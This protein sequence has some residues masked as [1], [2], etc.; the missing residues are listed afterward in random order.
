MRGSALLSIPLA[1]AAVRADATPVALT[2]EG[3]VLIQ[4]EGAIDLLEDDG[5]WASV[6]GLELG[7]TVEGGFQLDLESGLVEFGDGTQGQ[8]PL[9]GGS[10]T[11]RTYRS[12]VG[13]T[14][15]TVFDDCFLSRSGCGPG[16]ADA[17]IAALTGTSSSGIGFSL[18]LELIN[19][20]SVFDQATGLPVLPPELDRFETR[21]FELILSDGVGS[22]RVAGKIATLRPVPEP[23]LVSLLSFAAL[24][25]VGFRRSWSLRDRA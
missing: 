14:T 16:G 2:A 24:A 21:R 6:F 4:F 1:L 19:G 11:A 20:E 13:D 18:W 23:S 17:W 8:R 5:G 12:G 22:S 3:L 9:A 10:I 15:L 7:G 25:L